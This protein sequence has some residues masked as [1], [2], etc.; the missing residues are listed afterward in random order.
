MDGSSSSQNTPE[1][2][3][4]PV[5]MIVS[6][7]NQ[8]RM[9]FSNSALEELYR[10]IEQNSLIHPIKVRR[11]GD[12]KYMIVCGERR[13][14]AH[15]LGGFKTVRAVVQETTDTEAKLEA[16]VENQARVDITPLQEA[17]AYREMLDEGITVEDLAKRLGMKQVWR[18][19]ERTSL[20]NLTSEFQDAL[21]SSVISPSQAFE[22]S[23][24]TP[25]NQET[26]FR[27]IRDGKCRT[28][29]D[30]RA[31]STQLLASEEQTG[32][33][34]DNTVRAVEDEESADNTNKAELAKGI[35]RIVAAL[36]KD[37]GMMV[38]NGEVVGLSNHAEELEAFENQLAQ[39]ENIAKKGRAAC[40]AALNRNQAMGVNGA[41][42]ASVRR[43]R[44]E[45]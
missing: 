4:I 13:W 26:L 39:I 41:A 17:R 25:V 22:M 29:N 24:L 34:L 42:V 11:I 2:C 7:P 36:L 40:R 30:I 28:Y 5:D 15:Q 31:M 6:N 45:E 35:E 38:E 18:I 12:G 21:V 8:P 23:R 14:R 10:S 37:S 1:I 33:V 19:S 9:V 43:T 32:L 16:I 27:A 3:D 20:L 44:N